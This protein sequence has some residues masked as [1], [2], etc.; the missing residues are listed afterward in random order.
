MI[1]SLR[2]KVKRMFDE[3]FAPPRPCLETFFHGVIDKLV[4]ASDEILPVDQKLKKLQRDKLNALLSVQSELEGPQ[5]AEA[6]GYIDHDARWA[7]E[8]CFILLD[9]ELLSRA[10]DIRLLDKNRLYRKYPEIV[11]VSL[12]EALVLLK[13]TNVMIAALMSTKAVGHKFMLIDVCVRLSKDAGTEEKFGPGSG[14]QKDWTTLREIIYEREGGRPPKPCRVKRE[15]LKLSKALA[16]A[17]AGAAENDAPATKRQRPDPIVT[18]ERATQRTIT[19][20][21][22]MFGFGDREPQQVFSPPACEGTSRGAAT[23]SSSIGGITPEQQCVH[24]LP[25]EEVQPIAEGVVHTSGMGCSSET[26]STHS[27][28]DSDEQTIVFE[29]ISDPLGMFWCLSAE[30]SYSTQDS[31]GQAIVED[32]FDTSGMVCN[33]EMMSVYRTFREDFHAGDEAELR[34][35]QYAAGVLTA[36]ASQDS[37]VQGS[38]YVTCNL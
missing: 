17:T 7:I 21:D 13:Y 38:D 16:M 23:V 31:A 26:E 35:L 18:P 9:Y 28:H 4:S 11:D 3:A 34:D 36:V 33:S 30:S 29:D 15:A 10:A 32:V 2:A 14:S 37:G 5:M 24:T 27:F 19:Q 8:G 1:E 6:W 12:A 22:A 20:P 25:G